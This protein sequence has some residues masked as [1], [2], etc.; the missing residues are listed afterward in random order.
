MT[1]ALSNVSDQTIPPVAESQV[2]A[3]KMLPQSHVNSLIGDAKEKAKQ[4]GYN[5]ALAELNQRQSQTQM[6][7]QMGGFSQD[8]VRRVIAEEMAKVQ[9]RAHEEALRTQQESEGK[10][11]LNEL[12]TKINDAKTRL[13]DFDDITGAVNWAHIPEVLHYANM[14]DNAGDVLYDLA[15]NPAKIATL[16]G[17]TPDLAALEVKK[18]SSSIKQNQSGLDANVPQSP[19]GQF[20]PSNVG[21]DKRPSTASDY[22]SRYRGKG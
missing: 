8:D 1:D 12:S 16:R 17:L 7:S 10:R 20:K 6:P 13:P 9:Q 21:I 3:E 18:L 5:Q 11:I 15:K 14:A 19:L 4:A 2:A 22:A